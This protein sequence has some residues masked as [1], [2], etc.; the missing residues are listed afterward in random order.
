MRTPRQHAAETRAI[1]KTLPKTDAGIFGV[2]A[3]KKNKKEKRVALPA[4]QRAIRNDLMV[5]D[6]DNGA[7]AVTLAR[8]HR[9][10]KVGEVDDF[11]WLD[12][13]GAAESPDTAGLFNSYFEL[14]QTADGDAAPTWDFE[15][16]PAPLIDSRLDMG[17]TPGRLKK[18]KPQD[19]RVVLYGR[20]MQGEVFVRGKWQPIMETW[21][22]RAVNDN[23]DEVIEPKMEVARRAIS[24]LE[25]EDRNLFETLV[26]E[27]DLADMELVSS[28]ATTKEIGEAAGFGGKQAEAVGLDRTRRA[29]KVAERAFATI[30]RLNT[31]VYWWQRLVDDDLVPARLVKKRLAA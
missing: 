30:C 8:L 29:V 26:G 9:T 3:T 22:L 15:A 1:M 14:A 4:L 12:D 19:F 27:D 31:S 20:Q 7:A 17:L 5:D 28:G 16:E 11:S 23:V 25:V 21:K 24:P 2:V 18:V 13:A 6:R 10:M